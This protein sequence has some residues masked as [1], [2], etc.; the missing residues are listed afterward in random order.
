MDWISDVCSS[1]LKSETSPDV[2][3]SL[4]KVRAGGRNALTAPEART[5]CE[6]YGIPVPREGLAASADDAVRLAEGM[7][8]PVV[9]KIVSPQILHKTEA[10]G[11]LVGLRTPAAVRADRTSV[12]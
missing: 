11:V 2:R 3:S 6:I 5:L 10:G 4:D 7:G 12:V 9:L 1:D 8:F